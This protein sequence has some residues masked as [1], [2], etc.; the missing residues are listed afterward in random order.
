ML[1]DRPQIRKR[2]KDQDMYIYDFCRHM[3]GATVLAWEHIL[4]VWLLSKKVGQS[5]KK[6]WLSVAICDLTMKG[7]HL[8]TFQSSED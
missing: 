6:D 4:A 2:T 7:S 3:I 5:P 8:Q 1:S